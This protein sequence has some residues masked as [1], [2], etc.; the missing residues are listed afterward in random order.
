MICLIYRQKS[1][2]VWNVMNERASVFKQ[3]YNH[4]MS[5]NQG[6]LLLNP[7]RLN[8]VEK[9][10]KYVYVHFH[11]FLDTE[12]PQ[13]VKIVLGRE[14]HISLNNITADALV[15]QRWYMN[16]YGIVSVLPTR[17]YS[18]LSMEYIFW[19]F[20]SSVISL[21]LYG[22]QY[23]MIWGHWSKLKIILL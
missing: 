23:I 10:W 20:L 11:S 6:Y 17:R 22:T 1:G 15:T 4:V 13:V 3:S 8:F 5:L 7:L 16:R 9:T 12:K 2:V 14:G 18:S 21:H 19:P